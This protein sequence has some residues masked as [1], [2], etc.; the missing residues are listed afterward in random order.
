MLPDAERFRLL[1]GPY[2]PPR[3]RVDGFLTCRIRGRLKV[4]RIS[5]ARIQ[6][7][8][9]VNGQPFLIVTAAMAR[10]IRRES[11]TAICYWF[12]VTPQTVTKWRKSLAVPMTNAGTSRL[13][14]KWW[15]EGGVGEAT[16]PAREAAIRSPEFA[17]KIA[18]LKRGVPRPR[19][20][21][22][23]MR[24]GRLGKPQSEET[25]QKM[26]EAHARRR[27]LDRLGQQVAPS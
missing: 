21:V 24:R 18:G 10:A 7:P 12:G 16:R 3:C 6:W 4:A 14:S 22:E 17:A 9:A 25:R 15:A 19:H 23:A 20:V 26:R 11:A 13:R 1:H 8:C 27:R 2:R 5:D